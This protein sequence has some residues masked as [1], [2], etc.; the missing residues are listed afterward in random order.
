MVTTDHGLN[1][2]KLDKIDLDKFIAF[3]V[4][5]VGKNSHVCCHPIWCAKHNIKISN[6]PH[7][8][9]KLKHRIFVC[10]GLN[11]PLEFTY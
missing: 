6:G 1:A 5:C 4:F 11:V 10:S 8:L 2:P 9:I 7:C 3:L